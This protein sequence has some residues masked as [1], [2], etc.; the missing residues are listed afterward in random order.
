[1]LLVQQTY[2]NLQTEVEA[3]REIISTLREKY[4]HHDR[5]VKDLSREHHEEK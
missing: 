3:Q 2:D 1:M 5:E 4:K